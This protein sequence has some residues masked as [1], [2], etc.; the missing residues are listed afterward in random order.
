MDESAIVCR[1][2]CKSYRTH[3]F[4]RT[5]YIQALDCITLR[6]EYGRIVGLIGPNGAGKTT[7]MNLIAGVLHLDRGEILVRGYAVGSKEAKRS[8]G[9]VPEFPAFL[10]DYTVQ[11]MLNYHA[12]LCRL[13]RRHRR[14][15]TEQLLDRFGLQDMRTRRCGKLSQG[16]RQ[17]L[18]LAV[19]CVMQPGILILDEPSNGLDPVGIVDLRE[20]LRQFGEQGTAVLVSSHRLEE[21]ERLTT[22][23]IGIWDGRIIDV[24]KSLLD[25]GGRA[26]KIALDRLPPEGLSSVLPHEILKECGAEATVRINSPAEI[27]AV[28][29]RLDAAGLRVRRM[30]YNDHEESIEDVF[31]RLSRR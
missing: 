5:G 29:A 6:L 9:Y 26:L 4:G 25:G 8:L 3:R 30:Q 18:A 24:G 2:V 20:T 21:L 19:A 15:R 10:E 12:A 17:R 27:A 13:E 28:V 31:L 14:T 23:F 22:D 16:N 7:L 1:Q 11:A